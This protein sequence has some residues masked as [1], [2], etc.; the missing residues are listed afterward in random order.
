MCLLCVD[1]NFQTKPNKKNLKFE[2]SVPKLGWQ[3][4]EI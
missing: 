3:G 1:G 2:K 4:L